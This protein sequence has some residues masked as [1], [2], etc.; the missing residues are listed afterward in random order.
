M[1]NFC[2]MS[3][4]LLRLFYPQPGRVRM[5]EVNNPDLLLSRVF[6]EMRLSVLFIH[7]N[8][9]WKVQ[10]PRPVRHVLRNLTDHSKQ[11]PYT[12]S[13]Q[14]MHPSRVTIL[15]YIL[16]IIIIWIF[17]NSPRWQ[18]FWC[19]CSP[20]L[21]TCLILCHQ[22]LLKHVF[23]GNRV[24]WRKGKMMTTRMING[25]FPLVLQHEIYLIIGRY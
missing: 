4:G 12:V 8:L 1:R 7:F 9:T 24:S 15:Y 20:S 6:T 10:F 11:F 5:S 21:P 25:M 16:Q 23:E 22:R 3:F 14:H 2:C 13:R 17:F 19:R 18:F